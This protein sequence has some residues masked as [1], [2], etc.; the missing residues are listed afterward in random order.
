M[1]VIKYQI[2]GKADTKPLKDTEAAAQGMFKKISD[3]DNKL[4]AF[5]GVKVFAEV[6]KAVKGALAEYD[7]FQASLKGEN[8]F[9]KQ[10]DNIKT[11]M[12]GTLGTVRDELFAIV[13]D[14][15]GEDG[16]KKLE[17]IIPKIGAALIASFKVAAAIVSNIKDNFDNLLKPET[18]DDFFSH[19]KDVGSS[20]VAF[21]SNALKD[22]FQYAIDFF[23]WSFEDMNLPK[24]LWNGMAAFSRDFYELLGLM[25]KRINPAVQDFM[26]RRA[27]DVETGIYS[28]DAPPKFQLSEETKNAFSAVAS[29]LGKAAKA[30]AD[31]AAGG[32]VKELFDGA[33]G[34]AL[35]HLNTN[36]AAMNKARADK[37]P[38]KELKEAVKGLENQI[39]K[40]TGKSTAED[41]L[42]KLIFRAIG[43]LADVFANI[44]G[45]FAAFL[46]SFDVFLDVVGEVCAILE[47]ALSAIFKPIV[48]I[49]RQL[50]IVFGTFLNMLSPVLS[51]V[52]LVASAIQ[53]L[54]PVLY[55]IAYVFAAV[56][57]GFGHVYN[58]VSGIV[59][60]LTFGLVKMGSAPTNNRERLQEIWNSQ[61]DY[62]Q[63][64]DSNN[65]TSY[66][67]AGD[68]YIDINF[69][70]SYV[71]GDARE[72]AIMLRDEI[73]LAEK[74]GY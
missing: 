52:G 21:L 23:K 43:R 9:S 60:S 50:G 54:S 7:K 29:N 42:T 49:V 17:E 67:V 61:L 36:I 59:K 3:I 68:M 6:S 32:D 22:A 62:D 64:K 73:R 27:A 11:A 33:F 5:V 2:N 15:T 47:P 34:S 30:L 44:S 16:F 12:A 39:K 69:S 19:A 56:A 37:D 8:N 58:T 38:S 20:F 10:F 66:S 1:A 74:A 25:G 48:D 28:I 14:I 70:H 51:L 26:N 24:L 53:L 35:A 55:G 45:P 71:N 65:S 31:T 63:Y 46:N 18:W 41:D 57:D 13:G 72:I 40:T 4:K